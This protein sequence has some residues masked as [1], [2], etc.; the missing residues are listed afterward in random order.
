[1]PLI[2][3]IRVEDVPPSRPPVFPCGVDFPGGVNGKVHHPLRRRTRVIVDLAVRPPGPATVRR[4][5]EHDVL[6]PSPVV[7]PGNRDSPGGGVDVHRRNR[8]LPGSDLLGRP[9]LAVHTDLRAPGLAPIVGGL[10]HDVVRGKVPPR[11]ID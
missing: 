5:R 10:E 7:G 9:R 2:R 4:I 1:M 8:Y 6:I 11:E 3:G